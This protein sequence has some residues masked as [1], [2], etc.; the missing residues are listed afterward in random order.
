MTRA[1]IITVAFAGVL[2]IAAPF[3]QGWEG[4][5][6]EAHIPVPGDVL[7]ICDGSTRGVK[8]G[9]VANDAECDERLARD[10]STAAAAVDRLVKVKIS[11]TLRASLISFVFN[12]GEGNFAKSTLLRKLNAGDLR[13]ACRELPRWAYAAGRKLRGLER[14]RAAEQALCL[15][16]V[17]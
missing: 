11:D 14:R 3:V 12:V 7:T 4:R 1:R 8:L 16:G 5:T 10:L 9:M 6:Y 2:A 13:G 15:K 17:Q